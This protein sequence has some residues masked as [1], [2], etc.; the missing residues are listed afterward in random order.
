MHGELLLTRFYLCFLKRSI[1]NTPTAATEATETAMTTGVGK[2]EGCG[3]GFGV[4][5][6]SGVGEGVG[7]GEGVGV[8]SYAFQ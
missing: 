2:V 7:E 1:M 3:V 8:G 5:L 4:E 6:I